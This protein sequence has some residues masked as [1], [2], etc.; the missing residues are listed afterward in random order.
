MLAHSAYPAHLEVR[1]S[2]LLTIPLDDLSPCRRLLKTR[3]QI[4]PTAIPLTPKRD[5]AVMVILQ[6]IGERKSGRHKYYLTFYPDQHFHSWRAKYL[7]PQVN[8]RVE[9]TTYTYGTPSSPCLIE[10]LSSAS[11]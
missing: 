5:E 7:R 10:R 4:K 9:Y 3:N 2:R 6:R 1:R 11:Y 8:S